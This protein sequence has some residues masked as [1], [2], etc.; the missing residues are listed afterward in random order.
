MSAV[1]QIFTGFRAEVRARARRSSRCICAHACL[2]LL[3]ADTL[4]QVKSWQK[5]SSLA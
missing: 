1:S 2:S 5:S 4:Q 3:A